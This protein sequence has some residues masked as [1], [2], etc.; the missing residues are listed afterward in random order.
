MWVEI[1]QQD[2]Y[3]CARSGLERAHQ[4]QPRSATARAEID[5]PGGAGGEQRF[6]QPRGDMFVLSPNRGDKAQT[7]GRPIPNG[8][9][10]P[11]L[12]VDL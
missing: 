12:V 10:T 1:G 2:L 8:R 5:N 9:G 11:G 3:W 7:I 4:G 6:L